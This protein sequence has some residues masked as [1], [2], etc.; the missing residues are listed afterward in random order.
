MSKKDILKLIVFI[1]VVLILAKMIDNFEFFLGSF[2]KLLSL[3]SP[4]FWGIGIAYI[5]NALMVWIEKKLPNIR[6]IATL[7][8]VYV[9]F[10]G[11]L[12]IFSLL[13][14]PKIVQS[15]IDLGEKLPRYL[16]ES[17]EYVSKYV[18]D[19]SS[20]TGWD[21]SFLNIDDQTVG[22]ILG[23]FNTTFNSVFFTAINVTKNFLTFVLGIF[24]SIYLLYEKENYLEYA[25]KNIL[26][27][28]GAQKTVEILDYFKR[29][30]HIFKSFLVGKFIDSSIVGILCFAGLSLLKVNYA[31]L[32]SLIVGIT[33]MIPYF[34]PFIGAIPAIILTLFFDPLQAVWVALFILGLQQFDGW[35][36]GPAILGETMGISPLFIILA[37]LVG[38]GFAGPLGMLLAVPLFKSVSELWED[39]V[40]KK[41]KQIDR[42]K[43]KT[44]L[45]NINININFGDKDE[46]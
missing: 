33:N 32:L 40:E 12:T 42:P 45:K 10:I 37:I 1:S 20:T 39:M 4:L 18:N 13:I 14:A 44:G 41:L 9:V 5:L 8:I 28:F 27:L 7:G 17:Y 34:G 15:I 25:S 11:I 16:S 30:N 29:V 22:R 6:R 24:V 36:L 21:L 26:A 43:E 3:I 35:Y 46:K 38:G 2:D 23:I 19:L 31:L